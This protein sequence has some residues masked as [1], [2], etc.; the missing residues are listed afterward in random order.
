[1]SR[2]EKLRL[3]IEALGLGFGVWTTVTER[4]RSDR[5]DQKDEI[6][7]AMAHRIDELE[8]RLKGRKR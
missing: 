1:M 4:R 8:R 2:F 7:A 5:S 3:L 6:M